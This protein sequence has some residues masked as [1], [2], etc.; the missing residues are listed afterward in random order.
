MVPSTRGLLA[1]FEGGVFFPITTRGFHL[2]LVRENPRAERVRGELRRQ[3]R[4]EVKTR[5]E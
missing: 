5:Q 3:R 1:D 4:A 2:F